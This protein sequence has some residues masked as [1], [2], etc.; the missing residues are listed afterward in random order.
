[1]SRPRLIALLLA[2]GTLVVFLPAGGFGFLNY[3]DND[4]VTENAFVKNGLNWTDIR[5]A[6]TAFHAGNWHPLTWMSH[7]AD[8]TLFG[9]NPGA[10]HLVNVVFHAA[11]VALL[12]TLLLRLTGKI[13]PVTFITA[14]FAWH[15]LHVESVAWISERKDV[16]STFFALLTLSSYTKWAKTEGRESSAGMASPALV[17]RLASPG[18]F[19]AL[20]FFALGLLAKPMLVTLP[21]VLL[22][23]DY[24]PLQRFPLSAF[25]RSLLFEKIPFFTLAAFSCAVTYV[26]QQ[27][28]GAV[29]TL[30]Q[31]PFNLRFENALIAYGQYL[32][33]TIW[34]FNLAILYPL[35]NHLNWIHVAAATA[36]LLVISWLAWRARNTR[37][38]V[39]I[40]WL[41][42]LGTLV[43]VIGLVKVGN[44]A[45]ADRYT[46]FPLIG[47]F[48]AIGFGARDLAARFQFLKKPFIA[49]ALF[50][51]VACVALT[52]RQLQFW[53]DSETLFRR[54]LAVTPGNADAHINLG[55]ALEI[56]GRQTAALAEYRAAARLADDNAKAH[57]NIANLLSKTGQPSAALPEYR[58]AIAVGPDS[59]NYHTGLGAALAELGEFAEATN[60][61]TRAAQLNP[62][63]S[64]PIFETA[65]VLLKTGRDTEA[66]DE[67]RAALRIE[68]DN[69]QILTFA[70]QVLATDENAAIRDGA[71]AMALAVKA[72]AL[73]GGAQPSALDVL[74][75]ACAEAGRFDDARAATQKA[76]DLAAA[77]QMNGLEPL[78]TRLEFYKNHQPWRESFRATNAPASKID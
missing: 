13:W 32:L 22:L 50:I 23:L 42:F 14:L 21:L 20:L 74:G 24:W 45:L 70:A 34:P 28:G 29:R 15:P 60:E 40:G 19:L 43:P 27:R 72:S 47:I 7:M 35:P 36:A 51:L 11:N 57:F 66:V 73:T 48:I 1:M 37:A 59:A 46:Y 8:C 78:K 64:W 71:M 38:Y 67:L 12:F 39:T 52:E 10:H 65:K 5:W 63:N 56:S 44:T 77:A 49:A 17:P 30:E 75:M 58:R 61:L 25:R 3:D 33:D 69:Y 26:A 2:L 31:L 6:F 54:D 68:P 62:E 55:A 9:L 41:W 76:L 16:L 18:Y 4:Y 53:R